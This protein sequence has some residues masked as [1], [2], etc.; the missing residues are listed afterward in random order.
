MTISTGISGIIRPLR[1]PEVTGHWSLDEMM[2]LEIG[3]LVLK[4]GI[5][6]PKSISPSN[7]QFP[8]SNPKS[9]FT[10]LELLVTIS[11]IAVLASMLLTALTK[12]RQATWRA[13]ARDS[14]YQLVTAWKS[15]LNDYR[16]FPTIAIAEMDTNAV[17]ILMRPYRGFNV[18]SNIYME[19]TKK[20][21]SNGF[22]DPW[23]TLYQVRLDTNYDGKVTTPEH[24]IVGRSVV[25]WSKGQDTDSIADDIKSW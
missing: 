11:I 7:F 14:V 2:K 15:Y 13:R 12:A 18:Q 21:I 17:A 4:R 3:N 23:N 22:L 5:A 19:F 25:V 24:G 9:A 10:L 16:E 20:E 6:S 1:G 8:I